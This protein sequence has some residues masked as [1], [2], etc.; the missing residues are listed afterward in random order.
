MIYWP[1]I[2]CLFSVGNDITESFA[3]VSISSA[4]KTQQEAVPDPA[5]RLK[6]LRRKVREIEI[7]EAK[8]N[9]GEIENPEKDQLEKVKNKD[10]VLSEITRLEALV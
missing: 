8:L 2:L 10:Q 9:N 3:N 5:K 1:L 6:T 7:L 4:K